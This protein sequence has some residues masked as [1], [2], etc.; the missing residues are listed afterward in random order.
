MNNAPDNPPFTR[1]EDIQSVLFDFLSRE[2]STA[3][4]DVVREHLRRCEACRRSAAE[5]QHTVEL[6]R[7]A[8]RPDAAPAHLSEERHRRLVWAIM[9]PVLEWVDGHHVLVSITIAL[10]AVA[11]AIGL[12][13]EKPESAPPDDE[14]GVSVI[15]A[16]PRTV[17]TGAVSRPRGAEDATAVVRQAA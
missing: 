17:E 5:L 11:L 3:Q 1:C 8:D 6:L 9:H 7:A 2:L 10:L 4:S 16:P 13:R 14:E 12:L 15:L